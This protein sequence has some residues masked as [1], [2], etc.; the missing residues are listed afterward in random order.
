MQNKNGTCGH[1]IFALESDVPATVNTRPPSLGIILFESPSCRLAWWRTKGE[2]GPK[3]LCH[4]YTRR[5]ERGSKWGSD[6][7]ERKP[8]VRSGYLAILKRKTAFYSYG[9]ASLLLPR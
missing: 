2:S 7:R 4:G 6:G 5:S 9:D 8:H 1:A 3:V